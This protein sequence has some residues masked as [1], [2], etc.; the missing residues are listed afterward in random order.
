MTTPDPHLLI[1]GGAGYIGSHMCVEA[2]QAGYAVTALDNLSNSS[3]RAIA[4]IERITQKSLRF[5]EGDIRDR[6]LLQTLMTEQSFSGVVHFAGLK[7]V[8]ESTAHPLRYYDNNVTGTASLLEAMAATNHRRL[9]FSSSA[10]VYGAAEQMPLRED[11][12]TSAVNPY[13]Q[14]KLTV[15]HLLRDLHGSDGDWRI[16]I[17]RYFNPVG[18]HQTGEI[19]EDPND[20]PN[21]LMPFV[22]QVAVGRR[23]KLRVF[24]GDYPTRDGTGVRD[25]I[26]VVDLVRGHLKALEYLDTH[27]GLHTHNLG[28]GNGSSVL[29]VIKAFEAASGQKIP[30]EI[31]ERRPGDTATSYA[32][33]AKAASELGWHASFNLTDMCRDAWH[34]QSKH[35]HGY[36]S[37]D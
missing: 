8:G 26:H 28:T 11:N 27:P 31:V 23:D 13:G 7:A 5:I 24:G 29:D 21:N 4:A 3:T 2:L 6:A 16:S 19:G 32:D 36:G 15:E 25:Y 12:A 14:T 20:V 35:P 1:T 9:V 22:S 30:Y 34:W 37:Q 18:A 17:L 33:P 10:T